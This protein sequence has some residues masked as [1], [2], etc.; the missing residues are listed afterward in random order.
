[1]NLAPA[2]QEKLTTSEGPAGIGTLSKLAE[3]FTSPE[4]QEQVLE[5]IGGFKQSVQLE[6]IKQSGGNL[7]NIQGLKDEAL[8]GAFDTKMC[9]EGLCF[10][11]PEDLK[12]QLKEMIENNNT[13]S[14]KEIVKRL[15]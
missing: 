13:K 11:L 8:E 7:E 1:M 5:A 12:V 14:L 10:T 3:T 6:I 4:E 15:K 9:K 2:I